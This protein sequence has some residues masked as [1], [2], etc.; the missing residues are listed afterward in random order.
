MDREDRE[1]LIRIDENVKSLKDS[2][3]SQ[4]VR[5]EK[6]EHWR[7]SMTGGFAAIIA[8]FKFGQ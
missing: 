5:I 6:L 3:S 8:W 7:W 1:M 4:S 2:D